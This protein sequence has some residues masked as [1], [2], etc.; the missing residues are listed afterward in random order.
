MDRESFQIDVLR[1]DNKTYFCRDMSVVHV[2]VCLTNRLMF[3]NRNRSLMRQPLVL[4][5]IRLFSCQCGEL[6]WE[7]VALGQVKRDGNA[8]NWS[9]KPSIRSPDET[10][11]TRQHLSAHK[12][13]KEGKRRCKNTRLVTNCQTAAAPYLCLCPRTYAQE[14]RHNCAAVLRPLFSQIYVSTRGDRG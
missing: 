11:Q 4:D 9:N 5:F 12:L 2:H 1:C 10:V 8:S 13:K 14:Q 6:W 3:L 7:P